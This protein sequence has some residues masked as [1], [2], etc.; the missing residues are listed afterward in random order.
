MNANE[1]RELLMNVEQ[2]EQMVEEIRNATGDEAV[3]EILH[4]YGVKVEMEDVLNLRFEDEELG[5]DDL[6]TVA[7]GKCTYDSIFHKILWKFLQFAGLAP[8]NGC[9]LSQY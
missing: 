1:M 9:P 4:R 7:G 8:K 2:P 6:D 3:L 5:E